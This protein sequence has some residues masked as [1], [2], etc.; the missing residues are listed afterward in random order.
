MLAVHTSVVE[1]LPHQITAVYESM[2][3]RQPLRFLLAD[4]PGAG[5]TIMAGLLIKELI[6]RG[7]LQ[8]CLVVCPGSL[9][10]QWQDELYRRFHLPFEILTNDKLEA[11]RTGNWFL[12]ANLVIARLDK[13][14]RNEDVQQKLQ[15]PDCGWDLVVCDEAHKMSATFFGGE[16]KYTK[17]YRLGQLLSGLTRHFLLMTATPHNGKEEDFQLFM[18]LIDGD[19]FEGRF[20][21]GVH[22][23]EVSDLMRRM[24]KENLLKFDGAPL[25]PER[26]A[27]TVP[28]RLS[29][30]EARLYKAVTDYVREEFNRAEALENDRRAGTVGFALTILQRRLA[31]SPAAIHESLRR[32][33]ER[34][35]SRLR[36]LE[37]M[38]RGGE[39]TIAF[40]AAGPALDPED[41]E[42]LDEAPENE[43]EAAEQEVL[44]Q[45][46]AARSIAE[47]NAEIETL[48]QL[49]ALALEVRRSGTDTKWRELA[50]LLGEVFTAGGHT[51]RVAEPDVPYGAGAIP[52][53]TSSPR[54]KLVIFTEHRDTL[55][56]LHGRIATLLGRESSVVL[57]HGGMG[58]EDRL[59]AQEAFRHDPQV[60]VLL[61]TDAAG[62]GINLQ[63][64]HLMVNYDLP[65]N[66]NRL[67]QRFGRIHRIGQTE[68]CHLWNLVADETREGDVYRKLL[69]KLEQARQALGGQVFDVLGKLHFEGR[70]LRELLVE[71]IR[72]GEQPEVRARLTTAVDH[73]LDRGRIQDLLEDRALAH[74][75]MDAS[76]VRRIREDMVRAEARRLQ[77][78]YVE[79]FFREAFQRLGGAAKQ[80]E[81][82]RYEITH[83]PALVR[84]RDS[85]I[86][87]GEPVLPRYERIAFEKALVAPQGQPLAAFVCPGHPLLDA[88]IDLTLERHRDLLKRG[89]VLVDEGDEGDKPRVLFYLEHAIQDASLTRSGDR[90][91]VSKRMLYVELDADGVTRH[92]HYAP[93][94]DYRPLGED[95][96]GLEAILDRPECA[97]IGRELEKKAEGYAVAN[98]VPGHVT[99]VR[100]SRLALIAKTE[101][102][103]KDRLTKEINYWDHRAEELKLQ[104]Q[105]GK[106]G[107]R[108]NSGE[109]RKR[110]DMLQ[111]RLRRRLEE[112]KLEAQISPLPP[113]VLGGLLVVPKGLI[114][115]MG[116]R[117]SADPKTAVN[118]QESA[119]RA[120][121]IIMETERNLGFDPTDREFEKLGYDIESRVP[122]TGKLR[123]I[124]VKGRVSGAS[125]ITVTRN[126]ILYS[127]N[128]PE[129]FIL[130]IVEFRDDDGYRVRYVRRPFQREPDFGVTSVNYDFTELLARAEPP[131]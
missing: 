75:A 5:K 125:T 30:A 33:R 14:S 61:A 47:L 97:W 39:A 53:P 11:A 101:A 38:Q 79:S 114:N 96:P 28:Y 129:D 106:T 93:Y 81:V 102:A 63:R 84:N 50:S 22:V 70:P 54:Q 26:I 85:L 64:A 92:V 121:R 112:L 71:A 128:K 43:I 72:Y 2:L 37:V 76:R 48:R 3:P 46:T 67:E 58:R 95:D 99:E 49:E 34:L 17:R 21:D 88:V 16:I 29:D 113:V 86:G 19:R 56:Y 87:L 10:E 25:F 110:A 73:A 111:A 107:A 4:D 100:T 12:E 83:V 9:A 66:P 105:A 126:E 118:T 15:A 69:E 24:V 120:R 77:P 127:L 124:E 130:G 45:A 42:D 116:G 74:D 103:V 65:W 6:A 35:E 18:A 68:V 41:V 108:L 91:I 104:E 62:E 94:L 117:E 90:R 78:H 8:R 109:A 20:R 55:S 82:R 27:Y 119:A 23:A 98:V 44:D 60:Q 89:A 51:L 115:T 13:L 59:R 36:E 131:S 40:A 31:S 122:N 52:R 32:R 1:P 80:R 123:F 7:D 57:I